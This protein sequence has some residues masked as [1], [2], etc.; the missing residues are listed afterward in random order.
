MK[1][2]KGKKKKADQMK[3]GPKPEILKLEGNW[4]DAIKRSL[5]KKRPAKGW[6]KK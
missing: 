2:P 4:E 1:K 6:P 3:R 5:Q